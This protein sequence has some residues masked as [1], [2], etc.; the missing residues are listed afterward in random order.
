MESAS[1]S[2]DVLVDGVAEDVNAE[3]IHQTEAGCDELLLVEAES[4]ING[5]EIFLSV[6]K[7]PE[8][9]VNHNLDDDAVNADES[10]KAM[11]NDKSV[12]GDLLQKGIDPAPK[13]EPPVKA[14]KT[15]LERWQHPSLKLRAATETGPFKPR[16]KSQTNP[17]RVLTDIS[18]TTS[19]DPA[20]SPSRRE[21]E[22]TLRTSTE[23]SSIKTD[24]RTTRTVQ[25]TPILESWSFLQDSRN[26]KAKFVRDNKSGEK[27]SMRMKAG[28]SQ[29]SSL[30]AETRR[31]QPLHRLSCTVNS[32]K[33]DTSS[34][35][36]VFSFKSNERAERRK[37]FYTELQQKMHAKE[38]EMNQMQVRRQEKTEAEIKQFRRSLNFKATPMPSFYHVAVPPGS[39]GK[40]ALS[41]N[42]K[43][44]KAR[45]KSTNPGSRAADRSKSC[46]KEGSD[47]A[48]STNESVNTT[49]R[50]DALEKTNCPTGEHSG[51]S[52][53]S[54][55]LPTNQSCFLE[56]GVENKVVRRK[57]R[58]KERDTSMYKHCVSEIHKVMK[59]QR[60]EG[61]Q[62]V[63]AQRSSN[64]MARKEMKSSSGL[65]N[66]VVGVAS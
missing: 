29:P 18:K 47:Q 62:K 64:E 63:G 48:S 35:A 7:E 22:S 3:E 41:S 15:S 33:V 51:G 19:K 31:Y 42:N 24:I 5:R 52:A 26:Q 28:E 11:V 8:M 45:D 2:A 66:L 21:R 58:E 23:K 27:E 32:T 9:D 37:E 4:D 43:I 56:V 54:Q 38:A 53:S 16:V 1:N 44:N 39:D 36:A 55:T 57:E 25:R 20:K 34:S 46:L 6:N 65:G 40:K 59:G 50:T 61:K 13:N 49:E 30:K 10:S 12:N 17:A 14:N 60:A